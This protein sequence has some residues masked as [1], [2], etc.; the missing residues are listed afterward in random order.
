MLSR[1][2][3]EMRSCHEVSLIRIRRQMNFFDDTTRHLPF[4]VSY[5]CW[6]ITKGSEATTEGDQSTWIN[7]LL[8]SHG[9]IQWAVI[10]VHWEDFIVIFLCLFIIY[11]TYVVCRCLCV[12]VWYTHV[13][14]WMYLFGCA[15]MCVWVD[16]SIFLKFFSIFF[17]TSSLVTPRAHG[18]A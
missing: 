15:C 4:L 7:Q 10:G 14:V 1:P 18:V 9:N 17:E 12:C 8:H 3:V 16:V 13:F 6:E 5:D 11:F 2:P